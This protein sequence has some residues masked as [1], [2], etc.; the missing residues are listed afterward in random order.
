MVTIDAYLLLLFPQPRLTRSRGLRQESEESENLSTGRDGCVAPLPP[1]PLAV[2]PMV[3]LGWIKL[4]RRLLI[5]CLVIP[6]RRPHGLG[7]LSRRTLK[8]TK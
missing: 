1:N 4:P 3:I 8:T 7:L 6:T 2:S 5:M